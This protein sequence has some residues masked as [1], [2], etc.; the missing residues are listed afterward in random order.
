MATTLPLNAIRG[1]P[2]DQAATCVAPE[3]N[4]RSIEKF[5]LSAVT[6]IVVGIFAADQGILGAEAVFEGVL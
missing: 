6:V 1:M 4:A 5:E 3:A 2:F